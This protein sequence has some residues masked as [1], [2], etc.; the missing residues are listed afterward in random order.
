[1]PERKRYTYHVGYS[2]F[3]PWSRGIMSRED[4]LTRYRLER[5]LGHDVKIWRKPIDLDNRAWVLWKQ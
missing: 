2:P 1:M 5:L 3:R 4:S